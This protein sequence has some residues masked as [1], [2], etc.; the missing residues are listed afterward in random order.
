MNATEIRDLRLDRV[1][2]NPDQPRK[3]FD[4]GKLEELAM[5]ITEYGVL[6]PIVV[7]QRG[8]RFMII[9]GERRY[10]ASLLA[11]KSDIPARIIEA[12]DALVEELALLEN[13]QREDL[14]VIEEAEA[15]MRLLAR[16]WGLRKLADKLGYKKTGP[17]ADRISLLNLAPEY[18][19]MTARGD[20]TP[21]T[22]YEMSRLPVDKQ[23]IVFEK[24]RKGELNDAN[25]LYAYVAALVDIDRQAEI[26][27]LTP[28]TEYEKDSIETFE[29]LMKSAERLLGQLKSDNRMKHLEKASMH[30][31]VTPERIQFVIKGLQGV[32]KVFLV[33]DGVKEAQKEKAA[34]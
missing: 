21:G 3:D 34:V 26:F 12:D 24:I 9:C 23:H 27:A 2:A 22:A 17:I 29:K 19:A 6:E 7:C 15:Y 5:S 32:R 20:L 11:E 18:Q 14:N 1:Y 28:L 33:G 30:C 8:D 31:A 13:V 10:R 16:G 4:E 25:K